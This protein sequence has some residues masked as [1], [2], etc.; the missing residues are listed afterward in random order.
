MTI[1]TLTREE[2]ADRAQELAR[3]TGDL[4][5]LEREEEGHKREHSQT[6]AEFKKRRLELSRLI[7]KF[8]RA[9]RLGIE[10]RDVQ[11]KLFDEADGAHDRQC[12]LAPNAEP[13]TPAKKR[14]AKRGAAK[15]VSA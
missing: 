8:S 3:L 14:R 2:V 13:V 7:G 10:E 1:I 12:S 15:E 6:M 9:V 11:P 5:D 4:I